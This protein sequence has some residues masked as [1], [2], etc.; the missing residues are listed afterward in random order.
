MEKSLSS[1][2]ENSMLSK[3]FWRSNKRGTC[4]QSR[5]KMHSFCNTPMHA[6]QTD[7]TAIAQYTHKNIHVKRLAVTACCACAHGVNRVHLT[8][9]SVY[10]RPVRAINCSTRPACIVKLPTCTSARFKLD[11]LKRV[12]LYARHPSEAIHSC[13]EYRA[14]DSAF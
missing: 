10:L 12:Y 4:A 11:E 2:T 8:R 1:S 14:S 7:T 6:E 13:A 5:F 9:I 3:A